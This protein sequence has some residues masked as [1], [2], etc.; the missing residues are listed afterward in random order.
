M[1]LPSYPVHL[2]AKFLH[3][4][5]QKIVKL[6]GKQ[7]RHAVFFGG[8]FEEFGEVHVGREIGSV[9]LAVA[10]DGAFIQNEGREGVVEGVYAEH[11][12]W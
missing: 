12:R 1:Y 8:R 9:D 7:Q 4:G 11:V 6:F 2:T 3:T 5:R 10:A